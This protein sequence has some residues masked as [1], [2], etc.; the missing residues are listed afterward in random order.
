VLPFVTEV[1]RLPCVLQN[2]V[3][4][5]NNTAVKYDSYCSRLSDS[6]DCVPPLLLPAGVNGIEPCCDPRLEAQFFPLKNSVPALN[7]IRAVITASTVLLRTSPADPHM[8]RSVTQRNHAS[9]RV[10][11]WWFS[12]CSDRDVQVSPL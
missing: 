8:A 12:W 6:P 7:Y 11:A 9:Y 3:A 5:W 2:E 10:V 4:W 1:L